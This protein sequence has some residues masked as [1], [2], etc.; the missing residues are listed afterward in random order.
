MTNPTNEDE[1]KAIFDM[2]ILLEQKV[3]LINDRFS[4]LAK[5]LGYNA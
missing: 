5:E 4:K 2:L 1:I 3:T